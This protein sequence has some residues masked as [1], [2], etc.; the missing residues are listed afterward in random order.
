MMPY[1]SIFIQFI[2]VMTEIN[3]VNDLAIASRRRKKTRAAHGLLAAGQPAD[4]SAGQHPNHLPT[5]TA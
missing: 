3:V 1:G 2:F 5:S 4:R